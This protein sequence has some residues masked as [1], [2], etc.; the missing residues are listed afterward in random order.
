MVLRVTKGNIITIIEEFDADLEKKVLQIDFF[1]I[2]K[3]LK[4]KKNQY[5]LL[6]IIGNYVRY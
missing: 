3:K 2:K 5:F 6:F 4:R 1:F